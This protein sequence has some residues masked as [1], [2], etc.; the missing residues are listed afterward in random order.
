MSELPVPE[1]D[2]VIATCR[3]AGKEGLLLDKCSVAVGQGI[4]ALADR[5]R[6]KKALHADRVLCP[7]FVQHGPDIVA[8]SETHRWYI[9]CKGAGS[10][11]PQTQRNNFDRAIASVVSYFTDDGITLGLAVPATRPYRRFIRTRVP[12]ALR[13]RLNMWLLLYDPIT[14]QI[15][16]IAP[17]QGL[18]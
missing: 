9:E 10:G 14:R 7:V 2:V 8:L 13:K 3:W 12:P 16:D 4:D 17:D 6:L 18:H 1:I 15:E 5:E 11:T